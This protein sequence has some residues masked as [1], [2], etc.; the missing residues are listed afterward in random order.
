MPFVRFLAAL[1]LLIGLGTPALAREEI[2]SFDILLEV[3]A[4][5]SVRI[6]ETLAVNAEGN[7]VR[8]GIFRDI[9]NRLAGDG[10]RQII[11]PI[12]VEAVRRN[13]EAEPFEEEGI[14]G[15][16]RIRIGS[17]DRLL[18]RGVHEYEIVYTV[19]RAARLFEDFDEF[20]WNATGNYWA[21]P[22][23]SAEATVRL[24][25]GARIGE[26]NVY[27][28]GQGS[29]GSD[30]R[31]ARA[32][33]DTVVFTTTR[34]LA[35]REGMTVSVAFAKGAIAAP[36]GLDAARYWLSDYR[37]YVVPALLLLVVL[38][39][40]G[41]AWLNVGRDPKKGVIFPRFY[42]PKGFS[43]ALVHYVHH[44]GWRDSGWLA[45]SSALVSLAVK[46][47][48]EFDKQGKKTSLRLTGKEPDEPLSPGEAAIFADLKHLSP[49]TIDKK[50]GKAF[51]DSRQ[52]F[53]D[54]LERENR[55]LYF[56]NHVIYTI[57]GVLLGL[58]ALAVMVV[59]EVLP[60]LFLFGAAF[61]AVF[62]SLIGLGA[63][64]LWQGKGFGRIIAFGMLGMVVVNSGSMVI[65]FF[66]FSWINFPFVAAI[67][68]IAVT[69][70]FGI[71]M[72]APTVHGRK[73]MDEIEGFRM[74]LET[75]EKERLNFTGEPEM[76]VARYETILPYAMALRVEK[77]WSE[78][79]QGDLERN[80]IRDADKSY[81][82][83]WYHGGNFSSGSFTRSM[84]GVAAGLSSAM[85]SAQPVQASSSGTGGGGFSGGGGGGGGGGGW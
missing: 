24:P 4:D 54:V 84:S 10:G 36:E 15:G 35:P 41:L 76:S 9:P 46:G 12:H 60:P 43:P 72:R 1:V 66:D 50:S 20:Y 85:V 28:G 5:G 79:L 78:R 44:M 38:A 53:V 33:A 29:T 61:A 63:R 19:E 22:I 8:R 65:D 26:I 56:N 73:V 39:Y 17:S 57:F 81:A 55:A 37:D 82:P 32:G 64:S 30:A 14:D 77:P 59:F 34:P 68:I 6:T 70:I 40:N 80:A 58:G 2:R 25:Q 67:T 23:L 42:P 18:T 71:L 48:L 11:V 7:E 74:Y 13:G 49:V 16:L 51:G 3:Q 83:H 62:V 69:L 75:A 52:R 47:L 31:I 21:F 27:T 45:Y